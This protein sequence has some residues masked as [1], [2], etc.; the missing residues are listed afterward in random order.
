[1]AA[2]FWE[3]LFGFA[4]RTSGNSIELGTAK[5]TLIV[6]RGGATMPV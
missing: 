3:S 4:R 1:M 6:W 5:E 2:R